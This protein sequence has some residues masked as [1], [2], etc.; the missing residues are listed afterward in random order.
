MLTY[1]KI[2]GKLSFTESFQNNERRKNNFF[3]YDFNKDIIIIILKEVN[4]LK[5][6]INILDRREATRTKGLVGI[7][8]SSVSLVITVRDSLISIFKIT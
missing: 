1:Q 5:E 7:S 2:V 6:F 4:D 8:V 3:I